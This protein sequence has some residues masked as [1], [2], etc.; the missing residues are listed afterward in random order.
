MIY[1]QAELFI[2][3]DSINA[4]GPFWHPIQKKLY[5]VDI[6]K[7]QVHRYDPLTKQE[8]Q[9][10]FDKRV[11]C[12]VPLKNGKVVCAIHGS[13]VELDPET[14]ALKTLTG[15]ETDQPGNRSNDGKADSQGRLWVGTLNI[16]GEKQKASLYR[17]E[18]DLSITKV[19]SPFDLSNG[20]DWSPG[21]DR[22]YHI[23]TPPKKLYQYRFDAGSGE[24]S[25][26]KLISS[27]EH[28][29]GFPDGMCCDAEGKLWIALWGGK[30]VIRLD[31]DSGE[32]LAE[33]AVPA[34]NVSCCVFGGDDLDTLYISSA[35]QGLSEEDLKEYPLTGSIFTCKPGV[36][37]RPVNFFDYE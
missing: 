35:R 2:K 30:K 5:W 26:R 17:I 4:E 31:P 27:F 23:D 21:D 3:K 20:L 9:W 16:K 33:V 8:E 14:G 29:D 12:V 36:K 37:G 7:M 15:I 28:I 6:E 19:A 25:E 1:Y 34:I 13:L 18:K 22:F 10:Q 32:V 11:G 24:I